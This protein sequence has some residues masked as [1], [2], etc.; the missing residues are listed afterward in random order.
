MTTIHVQVPATTANIGAGFDCLGAALSLHNQFQFRLTGES[1]PFF[2]LE[3]VGADVET[4]KLEAT[5]DNLLYRAFAKVFET[6]GQ[7]VPHVNIAIDLKVP[8]S[9]GLGSS[10]TAIVGGLVGA[11][12]LARSP[13]GQREIMNLAIEMEGHPDNV[14]PALLG[15]CQLSVNHRQDWVICPW[16]WHENV[17][18][19]VAIP[20]FELSTEEA[21][22]VLPQQYARAQAIF[23]A[24]RLGLLPHGLAQNNP[25]YLTAA[26]DDQ[27]HQP[28]RKNL[29]KGYEQVQQAAIAAG[30]YGMVIS[31]AGPTL[32]A[33]ATP[34][35]AS[36]VATAMQTAWEGIGVKAIAHVL[37]IDQRGTVIL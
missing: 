22:A 7:P 19:V 36:Q 35:N 1:E 4:Q 25:E 5:A 21:R 23:N 3:L 26:L 20:D 18:P 17:V 31:G 14:V 33:L 8:L 12:A 16:A 30:A 6:L 2:S 10:A 37:E 11:N 9:R 34:E 13:L 24:S 15:G 27:I 29:I 32:L 28:Y